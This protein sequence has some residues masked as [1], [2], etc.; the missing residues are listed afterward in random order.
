M[1]AFYS[2][3]QLIPETIEK[4]GS[5]HYFP[6]SEAFYNLQSSLELAMHGFYSQAFVG[7]RSVLELSTMCV[8][9]I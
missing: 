3:G 8:I 7:L 6:Y 2:L 1:W 9:I 4:F 5:G